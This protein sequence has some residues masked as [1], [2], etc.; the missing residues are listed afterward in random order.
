M[1]RLVGIVFVIVLLMFFSVFVFKMLLDRPLFEATKEVDVYLDG[2]IDD[3]YK[4]IFK[5]NQIYISS[6]YL[7]DNEL[8]DYYWDKDYN[9]ISIFNNFRYDVI[10]YNEK[11][12]FYNKS[13]YNTDE[14]ILLKDGELYF[15]T[16]FIS[17]NYI[18]GLYVD[19][20]N[21]NVIIEINIRDYEVIKKSKLKFSA[22]SKSNTLQKLDMGEHIYVYNNEKN[23][24]I[25]ARVKDNVIGYIKISDIKPI[26]KTR[27]DTYEVLNKGEKVSMAWDLI[28]KQIEEF[29]PFEIPSAVDIIGP[30]WFELENTEEIFKDLSND[31]YIDFVKESGK[32]IWAVF[33][34]SFDPELT[35]TL[36]NDGVKRSEIANKIIEISI[37]KGFD[38]VNLDFENIYLKDKDV[39]SAFLK[40]LYCKAKEKGLL[41]TVDITIMSNAENWSMCYDRN[42]VGKY[43]DYIL[44]MAYDENVS[45]AAGS[46]SSLPWV[47][48]G[49]EN[50]LEYSK[51]EK[52]I[53]SIPFYTRLWEESLVSKNDIKSTALKIDSA[54]KAIDE[55]DIKLIY[56]DTTG[57]N[58]GETIID[59]V[60]YKIWNEDKTSLKNRLDII[61]KYDLLGYAVW[62]FKYGNDEMWE[63]LK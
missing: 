33:N 49:V 41:L 36:L 2:L 15:N 23:G 53:L 26:S 35:S 5:N 61:N 44:L 43:S 18:D 21:F 7:M 6:D 54:K 30:T 22:T 17:D 16:K 14:V 24:W 13:I 59:G 31:D 58:Y 3:G 55:L 20:D 11:K 37:N 48:Y 46:V 29:E 56:D 12:S 27:Y 51:S 39:F 28:Y 45:G 57:Q 34:N 25:L 60:K 50:L 63:V 10:N 38:A 8:L 9:K 40:E 32:S 52:I 42:V 47:E 62:A 1:K 19:V 4:H